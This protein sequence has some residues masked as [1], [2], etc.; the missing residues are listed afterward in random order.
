MK[1][2]ILIFYG[3]SVEE[4]QALTRITGTFHEIRFFNILWR[5]C[6]GISSW[7]EI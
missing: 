5:I 6:R 7:I 2:G 3:E 4:F 1:F